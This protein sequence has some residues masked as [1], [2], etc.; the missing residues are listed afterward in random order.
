MT[1][2]RVLIR[3]E[4]Y[5]DALVRVEQALAHSQQQKQREYEVVCS[6]LKVQIYLHL[7]IHIEESITTLQT[8]EQSGQIASLRNP[9]KVIFF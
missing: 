7:E 5:Y 4:L 1:I 6:L 8:I 2:V 9:F 3:N